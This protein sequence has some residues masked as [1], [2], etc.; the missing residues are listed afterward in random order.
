MPFKFYCPQGHLLEGHEA[1]MGQQCQCPMCGVIFL[2]PVVPAAG[3]APGY[4]QPGPAPGG[5]AGQG[6]GQ[7]YGQ[8]QAPASIAGMAAA[9]M[10]SVA[11]ADPVF[12]PGATGEGSEF[13]GVATSGASDFPGLVQQG[14]TAAATEFPGAGAPSAEPTTESASTPAAQAEPAPPKLYR[15]PCPKGHELETPEDMLGQEC[16]CPF[17]ETR[18]LLRLVDSVEHREEVAEKRRVRDEKIAKFWIR[19]AIVAVALVVIGV[20]AMVVYTK[21]RGS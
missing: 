13:P 12:N 18:F 9:F 21:T 16:L 10:P 4:M 2:M 19:G 17:C 11:P 7:G 15:I 5:F 3:F 6:Y 1:Q 8:V 14:G 20:I